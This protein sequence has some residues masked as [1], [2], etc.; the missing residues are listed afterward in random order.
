MKLSV[1][2]RT[3]FILH[4]IQKEDFYNIN[5]FIQEI[6]NR[7]FISQSD[8]FLT[9]KLLIGNIL[10]FSKSLSENQKNSI[11][12][13]INYTFHGIDDYSNVDMLEQ[14]KE[15]KEKID[16]IYDKN[17]MLGIDITV[18]RN[19]NI[20]E[21]SLFA[22][23]YLNDLNRLKG[24]Y[25]FNSKSINT[26]FEKNENNSLNNVEITY[27]IPSESNEVIP[28]LDN[29]YNY[30]FLIK[31]ECLYKV[32]DVQIDYN[33]NKAYIKMALI[34]QKIWNPGLKQ[35]VKKKILFN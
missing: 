4:I 1:D 33:A 31:N 8:N 34:P 17:D 5:L 22:V 18:F 23:N 28:L 27:L 6:N 13:Y 19:T 7:K 25:I 2:Q 11:K 21:F 16:S 10:S 12:E 32:I 30:N 15:L 26:S 14:Y 35:N 3:D 9:K 20:K 24:K 29:N